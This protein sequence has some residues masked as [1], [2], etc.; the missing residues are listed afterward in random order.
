[1]PILPP[2]IEEPGSTT[3]CNEL[4]GYSIRD[5][6]PARAS[7]EELLPIF[8]FDSTVSDYQIK[9]VQR[10]CSTPLIIEYDDLSAV[11]EITEIKPPYTITLPEENSMPK[12]MDLRYLSPSNNFQTAQQRYSRHSSATTSVDKETISTY[13]ALEDAQA[14]EIIVK[15]L[16]NAWETSKKLKI[17]LPKKYTYLDPTDL[18]QFNI[19]S[20]TI[21]VSRIIEIINNYS[22]LEITAEFEKSSNYIDIEQYKTNFA[23]FNGSANQ[24]IPLA[25]A[26]IPVIIDSYPLNDIIPEFYEDLSY[27]YALG[28]SYYSNWPGGDIYFSEDDVDFSSGAR[29]QTQAEVGSIISTNKSLADLYNH[30]YIDKETIID[31]IM[32]TT[33]TNIYTN[34]SDAELLTSIKNTFFIVNS[35]G[36][37]IIRAQNV[38]SLGNKK[39]QLSSLLRGLYHSYVNIPYH[40]PFTQQNIALITDTSLYKGDMEY[41]IYN[42]TFYYKGVTEGLLLESASTSNFMFKAKW[43]GA[44]PASHITASQLNSNIVIK[45]NSTSN[46]SSTAFLATPAI[47]VYKERLRIYDINNTLLSTIDDI[48]TETYTFNPTSVAKTT[49]DNFIFKVYRYSIMKGYDTE[50]RKCLYLPEFYDYLKYESPEL[51]YTFDVEPGNYTVTDKIGT[52]TSDLI[53]NKSLLNF[54]NSI[55]KEKRSSTIRLKAGEYLTTNGSSFGS[56]E[57][58]FS[59]CLII[60]INRQTIDDISIPILNREVSDKPYEINCNTYQFNN[61][62]AGTSRMFIIITSFGDATESIEKIYINNILYEENISNSIKDWSGDLIIGNYDTVISDFDI[63]IEFLSYYNNYVFT[64][65]EVSE[66]YNR[67]RE[68]L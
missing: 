56:D 47:E 63:S 31:I 38:I 68:L 60:N 22:T 51:L 21:I 67:Y 20:G 3:P 27:L 61:T 25:A 30:N 58:N 29:I 33:P 8:F 7:L 23:F 10:G 41:G 42:N 32:Y 16:I 55:F 65:E 19:D 2:P 62:I 14:K 52:T 57:Y 18:I 66:L 4:V 54:K 1:M 37:E 43:A 36:G 6:I 28:G 39:Y 11:L 48:T 34:L 13:V 49:S 53:A 26:M 35:N 12:E 5:R 40:D 15:L 24:K 45:W 44:S 50:F 46:F 64:A 9:F 59:I 17:V